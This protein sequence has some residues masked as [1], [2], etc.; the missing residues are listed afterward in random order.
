MLLIYR[1]IQEEAVP[2]NTRNDRDTA[3]LVKVYADWREARNKLCGES[4]SVQLDGYVPVLSA[5]MPCE[6]LD[7]WLQRFVLE[8]KWRDGSPYPA[9]SL[10]RLFVGI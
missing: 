2:K 8:V 9:I 3:W 6:V 4:D 5:D 7:F 10:K 1:K